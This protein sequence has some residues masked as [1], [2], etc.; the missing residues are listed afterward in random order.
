[1]MAHRC[2][3]SDFRSA[4]CVRDA[5]LEPAIGR[6]I[7]ALA[8]VRKPALLR[9]LFAV[10]ATSPAQIALE[11]KSGIVKAADLHGLLEFHRRHPGYRP[12]LICDAGAMPAAERVGVEAVTWSNFL[13]YG[14]PGA[15]GVN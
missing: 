11:I 2:S 15:I 4:S 12:L 10:C 1:M 7:L 13:I 3:D 8:P 14:L 5:I 6:D 9:Q